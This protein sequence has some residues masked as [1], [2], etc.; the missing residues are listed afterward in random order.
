VTTGWAKLRRWSPP[1]N[2]RF[3]LKSRV[4]KPRRAV[5]EPASSLKS[6]AFSPF[7][8]R[9]RDSQCLPPLRQRSDVL[10][11]VAT[12]RTGQPLATRGEAPGDLRQV[13]NRPAGV[14][15]AHTKYFASWA[16]SVIDGSSVGRIAVFV[17]TMRIESG[18]RLAL[19]DAAHKLKGSCLSVGV[20]R[21][22]ALCA[23][24]ES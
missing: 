5:R 9:G 4:S 12:D 19:R 18:A 2:R 13:F 24:L 23:S 10:A 20:P 14:V 8:L 16:D 6:R 1:S 11:I 3:P 21:M 22:A 17:S 15:S 7:A